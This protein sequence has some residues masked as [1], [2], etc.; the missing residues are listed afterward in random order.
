[1]TPRW[2][3]LA[4]AL[5]FAALVLA[6][7]HAQQ[8]SQT[9]QHDQH[10]PATA[11]EPAHAASASPQ[12]EMKDM[13]SRTKEADAKLKALV[14]KMNV[15]TGAA[16]TNAIA[17]VLTA[18]VEDHHNT[19]EAMMANMMSMS[20]MMGGRGAHTGGAQEASPK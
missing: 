2:A 4:M 13:M 8:P 12:A 18:L 9:T 11:S 3:I 5:V 16:K 7:L 14:T 1:M 15:A 19:C 10:H 17:E 20:S 6:R